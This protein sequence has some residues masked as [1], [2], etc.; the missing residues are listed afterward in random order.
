[1]SFNTDEKIVNLYNTPWHKQISQVLLPEAQLTYR[2]GT[3]LING[4]DFE[5]FANFSGPERGWLYDRQSTSL[6]QYGASGNHSIALSLQNKQT[7]TFGMQSFKRV[8]TASSQMTIKAKFKTNDSVKV[9]YY[10]QGRKKRQK[11]FDAFKNNEKHLIDSTEITGNGAWQ[12]IEVDF[13]SPRIGYK[14]YRVLVEFELM[15]EN[16]NETENE[17]KAQVDV[18]DFSLIEW[19]N[20]FTSSPTPQLFSIKSQ[21]PAFIGLNKNTDKVITL[22]Y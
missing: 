8:F 7:T 2:F 17:K 9:S 1:M 22:K 15:N 16:K 19:Q 14:S 5:S 13:N 6:N 10:W 3:N 18:D 11:L 12:N 4:S 21:Q 20:A